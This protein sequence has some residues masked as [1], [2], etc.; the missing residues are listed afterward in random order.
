M[1][2]CACQHLYLLCVCVCVGP[3]QIQ[4]HT[5][6]RVGAGDRIWAPVLQYPNRTL[7]QEN[8][9]PAF[10]LHPLDPIKLYPS[11]TTFSCFTDFAVSSWEKME[12]IAW[13]GCSY[14][15]GATRGLTRP[16]RLHYT[17][18]WVGSV[19]GTCKKWLCW[20]LVSA[21]VRLRSLY[22]M[23]FIAH[24][25]GVWDVEM[26]GKAWGGGERWHRGWRV[27]SCV[28]VSCTVRYKYHNTVC[29]VLSMWLVL[30]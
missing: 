7:C 3:N 30:I 25:R 24:Y 27:C 1:C 10:W 16:C 21:Y 22:S 11:R 28:Q 19:G 13:G 12:I 29:A 20:S 8:H 2:V 18:G 23:C 5:G 6:T 9:L 17:P 4:D 15:S 26:N 14:G